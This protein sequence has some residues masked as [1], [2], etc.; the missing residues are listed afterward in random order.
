MAT[1]TS[2]EILFLIKMKDQAS[3]ELKKVGV[4]I[5]DVGK[6]A[7]QT[8][9]RFQMVSARANQMRAS[10]LSLRTAIAGVGVAAFF[11]AVIRETAQSE[12]ATAALAS[13]LQST[14]QQARYTVEG[15]QQYADKLSDLSGIDDETIQ[16][17]QAIL[18]Q[19]KNLSRDGFKE[20]TAAAVNLSVR[21]GRD[22]SGA[23]RQL[24]VALEDPISGMES[25]RRVGI[26]FDEAT[27]RNIKSLVQHGDTFKA[28]K[29]ILDEVS[30]ATAGAAEA[31]G[32]TLGGALSRLSVTWGN[33]LEAIGTGPF[34]EQV[35]RLAR[36]MSDLL[37]KGF[38]DAKDAGKALAD[39]L[40]LIDLEALDKWAEDA[41][42]AFGFDGGLAQYI[43]DSK[44]ELQSLIEWFRTADAWLKDFDQ[45]VYDAGARTGQ[46]IKGFINRNSPIAGSL[47]GLDPDAPTFEDPASQRGRRG[48]QSASGKLAVKRAQ[49]TAAAL[50]EQAAAWRAAK[51]ARDELARFATGGGDAGGDGGGILGDPNKLEAAREK[52][53]ALKAAIAALKDNVA[54]LQDASVSDYQDTQKLADAQAAAAEIVRQAGA[55][56]GYTKDQ[57][58]ALLLEQ[59]K[60]ITQKDDL[61]ATFKA[62]ADAEKKAD[63]ERETS[64]KNLTIEAEKVQAI[65]ALGSIDTKQR[66]EAIAILERQAEL[67]KEGAFLTDQEADAV[68]RL[69][70]A[71]YD[72]EHRSQTFAEAVQAAFQ[73][74]RDN[75]REGAQVVMNAFDV[76]FNAMSSALDQ[77]VES[78]KIKFKSLIRSM[79]A[80]LAKLAANWTFN[81]LIGLALGAATG[82]AGPGNLS[83][84]TLPGNEVLPSAKGRVINRPTLIPFARGGKMALAGEAGTEAIMPLARLPSGDLGVKAQASGGNTFVANVTVNVEGNT[85]K[86]DAEAIGRNVKEA[87][88]SAFIRL[89]QREMR[90]GGLLGPKP[91]G[92]LA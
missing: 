11:R 16:G 67:R 12:A 84:F 15:L 44:N 50:K 56:F 51:A 55:G 47:L 39:V 29:V 27:K 45:A 22:V 82:G 64:I 1:P 77:F 69:A 43:R 90:S 68:R 59:S 46:A 80:D 4:S 49:E 35:A 89:L 53:E 10:F 74:F 87:V 73:R 85:T 92:V 62:L 41:S 66:A 61:T 86:D 26:V 83:G 24:G 91:G 14:G 21:M 38:D 52:V 65:A 79:I 48:F 7:Q 28:Q 81:Q 20:A 60:L 17:A 76:G 30:R 31:Y 23:A 5:G 33:F 63:D 70:D 19:F 8:Q 88:E 71:Q 13:A 57:L 18:L 2:E 9:T 75:A 42:K 40:K 3:A 37:K 34:S 25:L 54:L 36:Q 6:Q 78:G 72:A 58:V 32:Q